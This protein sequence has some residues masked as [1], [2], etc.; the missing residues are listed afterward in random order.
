[1]K[2]DTKLENCHNRRNGISPVSCTDIKVT[3]IKPVK[4][5]SENYKKGTFSKIPKLISYKISEN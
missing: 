1:M 3:G 2:T 4:I 5:S